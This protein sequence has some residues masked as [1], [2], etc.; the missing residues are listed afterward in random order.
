MEE[1]NL[2]AI[3]WE[4]EEKKGS[5]KKNMDRKK[6]RIKERIRHEEKKVT[7]TEEKKN[8]SREL[9]FIHHTSDKKAF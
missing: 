4:H 8:T 5:I 7:Y 2:K 6:D 1:E 3:R 9:I